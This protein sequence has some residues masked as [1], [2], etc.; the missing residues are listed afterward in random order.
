MKPHVHTHQRT[1]N[2]GKGDAESSSAGIWSDEIENV[3]CRQR[4]LDTNI[5]SRSLWGFV[6]RRDLQYSGVRHDL[7]FL[8]PFPQTHVKLQS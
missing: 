5:E 8:R 6:A 2:N 4:K 1:Q 7:R 3:R